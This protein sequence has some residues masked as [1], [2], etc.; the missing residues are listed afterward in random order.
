MNRQLAY[1]CALKGFQKRQGQR[2][3]LK[4]QFKFSVQSNRLPPF[5]LDLLLNAVNFLHQCCNELVLANLADNLALLENKTNTL[6]ARNAEVC[7]S[8]F[9][10]AVYHT[11]HNGNLNIFLYA[12][13]FFLYLIRDRNQVYL[14]SAAGRAGNEGYTELAQTKAFQNFFCRADFFD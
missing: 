8:R 10:G 4:D 1:L 3:F 6:A 13:A 2:N 11:A 12:S 14:C 9:S 7:L 5:R